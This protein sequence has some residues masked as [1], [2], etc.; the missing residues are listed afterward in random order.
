VTNKEVDI[1][2][3]ASELM[4]EL[5]NRMPVDALKAVPEKI[6][7]RI[8]DFMIANGYRIVFDR[9]YLQAEP[10]RPPE[11]L[12]CDCPE[13]CKVCGGRIKACERIGHRSADD[14]TVWHECPGDA[15]KSLPTKE[16]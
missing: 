10:R 6:A 1:S 8:G 7:V 14:R 2:A 12:V 3:G 15:K 16:G 13:V 4:A 11:P 9:W 5:F